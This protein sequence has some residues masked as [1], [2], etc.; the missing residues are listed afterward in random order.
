MLWKNL[1]NK[2]IAIWGMGKEG[3]ATQQALLKHVVNPTI[4][5]ITE[6]NPADILKCDIL[7]KS[8]GI[9]LYRSEIQQAKK[10]GIICTSGTNLFLANKP[11]H[12]KV[13]GITGTKGKSTTTALLYHTLKTTGI[14][15]EMGGNIGKPLLEL[16]DK[17]TD[18]IIGELS[19][20][21]CADLIEKIDISVLT[22]LY[23]EHLQWH[24]SHERY[25]QDKINML[26]H[27]AIQI[28]NGAQADVRLFSSKLSNP[29]F[30][31]TNDGMHLKDDLFYDKENPLFDTRYLNLRGEHNAQNA[32]AILEI[33]K[34]LGVDFSFCKKAF[35]TFEALPHRLQIVGVQ[36]NITFVDDSISTTPETAVAAVKAFDK[37]QFITLIIG[38]MDR[39][40]DFSVLIEFLKSI[41]ERCC[42]IT[43]PD[44]G[45]RAYQHAIKSELTAYKTNN[46]SAAVQYA[47]KY[48]PSGGT[49]LLSPASP[50][51][52][53]YKNFEER[54]FDFQKNI[55]QKANK[56]KDVHKTFKVSS[57]AHK[58][59]SLPS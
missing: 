20:Y 52:N 33:S 59:H 55:F 25:Y 51:Y 46:M 37:G 53:Q 48:T 57:V 38:G 9:S 6:E 8:P 28:I 32:C 54:G 50:S 45:E 13:I 3:Q 30:F 29:V 1:S 36:N 49:V 23:H 56:V 58:D 34:R 27:S 15:V 10:A 35:Q 47:Q 26:K 7:V 5:P 41:K 31:N 42:L 18:I 4:I 14:R 17:S 21:Q 24:G 22:N 44:T 16:V 11:S 40:Q 2:K 43:L 39:G 19:S 12:V